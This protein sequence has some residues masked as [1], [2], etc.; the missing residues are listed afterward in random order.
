MNALYKVHE[1]EPLKD[2]AII[3]KRNTLKW[4]VIINQ[5]RSDN[6]VFNKSVILLSVNNPL[7]VEYSMEREVSV[8]IKGKNVFRKC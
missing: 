5:I 8:L 2:L 6:R 3:S 7:I 1:T 4:L